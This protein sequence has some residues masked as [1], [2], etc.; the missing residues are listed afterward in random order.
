M[1]RKKATGISS[2]VREII[3]T[4]DEGCIF[5]KKQYRMSDFAGYGRQI[6]HYIGRG[7]GGLGVPQNLAW[8]CAY[9]HQMYDN[10]LY[11]EEMKNIFAEYLMKIYPDWDPK[12]LVYS[13]WADFEIR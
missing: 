5:C 1:Q 4:R 10:G 7:Q 8:G 11:H 12:K 2:K 3:H 13:K 6:M 9:H